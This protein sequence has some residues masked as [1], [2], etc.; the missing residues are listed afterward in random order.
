M[1]SNNTK[2][3]RKRNAMRLQL[4][5]AKWSIVAIMLL[6][7][8]TSFGQTEVSSDTLKGWTLEQC[9]RYALTNNLSVK[10]Q[11]LGIKIQENTYNAS[12]YGLLPSISADLSQST[13]FGRALDQT[14]Y[15]FV[16]QTVSYANGSINANMVLFDGMQ[17]QNTIKKNR[18][19]LLASTSEFEKLKNDI[20]LNIAASYLQILLN[21][22]LCQINENQLA[23][24]RDQ[25]AQTQ[26]LVDA[27]KVVMGNL[28]DI[29]AQ[30]ATEELQ[31][32]TAQNNLALSRLQLAQLLDLKDT[33]FHIVQP[34]LGAVDVALL[35]SDVQSTYQVA[36]ANLPQIKTAKF[37]VESAKRSIKISKGQY[38]PQL[39]VSASY[40]SNYSVIDKWIFEPS[41]YAFMDQVRDRKSIGVQFR[42]SIPIFSGF[43][44]R[45]GVSNSKV[46][47]QRALLD[48]QV[49]QNTLFKE[50]QQ[51][52]A[53]AGAAYKRYAASMKSVETLG[54]SFEYTQ[55]R[56]NL[57]LINSLDY[58]TAKNKLTKAKS[59]LL[60]ARYE[61][62]FKSKILDFYKGIP[63]TL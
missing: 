43:S 51:A 28:L 52:S 56:F 20:S 39:S 16:D 48:L 2:F 40:G 13:T 19:D 12:R 58:N 62:I 7:G 17:K 53:D 14:Q 25:V 45:Y 49:Q 38:L 55:N 23:L 50:I 44:T 32:V 18:F 6:M 24:T 54:L 42:L 46:G 26:K 8:N 21:Q 3:Y 61:Y 63:I 41:D 35:S 22:E 60:Q 4:I 34:N 27:G 1:S 37:K 15:K 10:S 47:Y 36:E 33:S 5:Q 59:D 30:Q 31:L 9:I 57:G 11:D 29:E